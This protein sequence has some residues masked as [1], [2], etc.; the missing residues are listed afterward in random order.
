MSANLIKLLLIEDDDVDREVVHRLIGADYVVHDA[1]TGNQALTLVRTLQPACVLLDYRL[2][3]I[4]GLELLAFCVRDNIPVVVLTGEESPE[5]IVR[6]MQQG[7]QDYLVKDHISRASLDRA[8]ANA[9]EKVALRIDLEEKQRRLAAQAAD[10]EE[11]NRQ[12]RELASAL[13]LAEQRERRRISQILHDNVQQMLYGVQ[14]RAHLIGLDIAPDTQPEVYTHLQEIDSLVKDAIQ[15]TRT[16]T[17]QISPPVLRDE[18]LDA[19]FRWLVSQMRETHDLR[20]EL[21]CEAETQAPNEDLRVLLFQ[22]VRE[23]LFNVVKHAG[24]REAQI[25]LSK[26]DDQIVITVEDEGRGFDVNKLSMSN[27]SGGFGLYS[28]QERL[29]LFGGQLELYSQPGSGT[30]ATIHV[31]G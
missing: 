18:G 6:A 4:D 12:V 17:V 27:R 31:P 19:V 28:I 8:I 15:T 29:S 9:I 21:L 10:L 25:K 3:D 24:T 22:L 30:R 14:M 26:E 1:P 16:L 5:V 2:P 7:A 11:K 20:V 13:T 23:L